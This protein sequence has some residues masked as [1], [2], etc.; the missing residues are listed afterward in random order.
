MPE[1]HRSAPALPRSNVTQ[2]RYRSRGRDLI[3]MAHCGRASAGRAPDAVHRRRDPSAAYGGAG[4]GLLVTA[5]S[6]LF[7]YLLF[8]GSVVSLIPTGQPRLSFFF[9]IGVIISV[10]LEWF[11]GSNPALESAKARLESAN[12]ELSRR[13]E[14]LTHSNEELQRFAYAL[15]HDLQIRYEPSSMFTE[16]LAPSQKLE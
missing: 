7:A 12:H 1:W 2:L 9:V 14:A 5:I 6:G 15:S 13:S 4:P 8:S 11:R 16:R 10:V 3:A